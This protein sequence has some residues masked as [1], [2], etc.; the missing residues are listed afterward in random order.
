MRVLLDECLPVGLRNELG[1]H[2]VLTVRQANLTGKKDRELLSA[3]SGRFDAFLTV[4]RS[5]QW[6]QQVGNFDLAVVLIRARSNSLPSL[7]PLVPLLLQALARAERGQ[8]SRVAL[9]SEARGN[10]TSNRTPRAGDC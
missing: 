7:L 1:G 10:E 3:A 4:D 9:P 8:V 5:L 6:Q 2:Q